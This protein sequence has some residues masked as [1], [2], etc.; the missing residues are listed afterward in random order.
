MDVFADRKFRVPYG[1]KNLRIWKEGP[2][3]DDPATIGR[4][5]DL[6]PF[7]KVSLDFGLG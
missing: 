2:R 1:K 5:P 7:A 6:A 4:C 3:L